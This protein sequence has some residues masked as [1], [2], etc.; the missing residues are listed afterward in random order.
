VPRRIERRLDAR[1][2]DNATLDG[3]GPQLFLRRGRVSTGRL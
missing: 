2:L 3:V 1:L